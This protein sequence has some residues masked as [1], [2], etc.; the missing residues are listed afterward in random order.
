MISR[1]F[2]E[3]PKFSFVVSIVI[4]LAGLIAML[5]LPVTQYPDIVPSQV[6]ITSAYPGADALTVQQTVV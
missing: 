1:F 6:Q 4:T 5:A 3:R 2:I